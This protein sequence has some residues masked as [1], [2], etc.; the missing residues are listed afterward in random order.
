MA[1][2]EK[3]GGEKEEEADD[4]DIDDGDDDDD[5][6]SPHAECWSFSLFVAGPASGVTKCF[7]LRRLIG[8][9]AAQVVL[10]PI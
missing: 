3:E 9:T 4:G 1:G 2:P 8:S 5:E 7:V 6:T 10:R